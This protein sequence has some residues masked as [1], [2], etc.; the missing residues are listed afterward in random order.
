MW[1]QHR[2]INISRQDHRTNDI[3]NNKIIKKNIKR[4]YKSKKKLDRLFISWGKEEN[5]LPVE[6]LE[7]LV[8]GKIRR[9]RK[10]F[11]T[12]EDSVMNIFR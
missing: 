4:D 1:L 3:K 7:R 12:E 10:R 5:V 8:I 11:Q 6:A 9:E 2:M